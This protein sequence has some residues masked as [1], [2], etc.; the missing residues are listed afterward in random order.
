M[1]W[2]WADKFRF[3]FLD[4]VSMVAALIEKWEP[5]GCATE[6]ECE[7]SLYLYLHA[8]VG[9][10]FVT[11]QFAYGR[12]RADIV[13]GDKVLIELK[14]NLDTTAKLQLIGGQLSQYD[15]WDGR[16]V[17]LLTG[18]TEPN[19]LKELKQFISKQGTAGR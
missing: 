2:N 12:V 9:D 7:N 8:A 17:V 14:H 11:K 4:S 15:D 13:V 19:L 5:R 3:K 1:P 16:V 6:K 10:V 18:E